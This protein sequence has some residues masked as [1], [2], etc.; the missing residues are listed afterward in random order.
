[1]R[2][3]CGFMGVDSKVVQFCGSIMYTLRHR[4]LLNCAALDT[5]SP[6]QARYAPYR[7]GVPFLR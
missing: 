1:V 4:L 7:R 2:G 3:G 5:S 6:R